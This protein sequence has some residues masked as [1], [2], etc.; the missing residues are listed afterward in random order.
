[1]K[2]F[3]W[4]DNSG[5]L[6]VCLPDDLVERLGLKEGDEVEVTADAS[7]AL[8]IAKAVQPPVSDPENGI[9]PWTPLFFRTSAPYSA[10]R[11]G[12]FTSHRQ[13]KTPDRRRSLCSQHRP[14]KQ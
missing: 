11:S 4:D 9:L 1:M 5:D 12:T 13:V 14:G 6:G 3:K 10:R 7:G 8:L 2:I